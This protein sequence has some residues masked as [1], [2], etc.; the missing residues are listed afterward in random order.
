MFQLVTP[1]RSIGMCGYTAVPKTDVLVEI[2]C[3]KSE[4]QTSVDTKKNF[5]CVSNCRYCADRAQDLR[6]PANDNVLRVL[7]ISSKSVYCR[8]SY[9]RTREH[10]EIVT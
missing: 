4:R 10:R 9:S 1:Q 3:G 2:S 7:Q 5:A 6:Q 8:R